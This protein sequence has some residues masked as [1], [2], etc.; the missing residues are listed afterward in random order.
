MSKPEMVVDIPT[1]QSFL[2]H[3]VRVSLLHTHLDNAL[4]M[5]VRSFSGVSIE[6]ALETV[7][8]TGSKQL[9]KWVRDL[10]TTRLGKGEA[11][12]LLE[13]YLQ[14]CERLTRERNELIHN[15]VGRERD[16]VAF[17]MRKRDG[18][19][20]DLPKPEVLQKLGDDLAELVKDMHFSRLSGLI[21]VALLNVATTGS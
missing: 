1:D 20:V 19:W 3:F 12:D 6:E 5:Y 4:A 21:G 8:F 14:R 13:S 2:F 16:G 10:A 11:L 18:S 15:L 17:V 9:R 7:G